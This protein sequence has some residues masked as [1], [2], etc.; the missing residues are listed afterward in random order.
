VLNDAHRAK[1]ARVK[2]LSEN[3]ICEVWGEMES[4]WGLSKVG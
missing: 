3:E 1:M 4:A 2:N